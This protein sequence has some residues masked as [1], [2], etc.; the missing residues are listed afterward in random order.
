[1]IL[2]GSGVGGVVVVVDRCCVVVPGGLG[3]GDACADA[4]ELS[5]ESCLSDFSGVTLLHATTFVP[6]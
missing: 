6:A 4:S 1:M 3:G 5:H 2:R